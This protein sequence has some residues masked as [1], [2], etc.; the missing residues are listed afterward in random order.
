M[1]TLKARQR[2]RAR[3]KWIVA[4]FVMAAAIE[5]ALCWWLALKPERLAPSRTE[6]VGEWRLVHQSGWGYRGLTLM[7]D[8]EA[9]DA[10]TKGLEEA[11]LEAARQSSA[12]AA[13][14]TITKTITVPIRGLDKLVLG[15]PTDQP[16]LVTAGPRPQM[17]SWVPS[18][19]FAESPHMEA[20]AFGWP[21]LAMR[22]SAE[23]DPS[24]GKQQPFS[25]VR[26]LH[27]EPA[28]R[29]LE[30]RVPVG[31]IWKGMLVDI[32]TVG[33]GMSVAIVLAPVLRR[34]IRRARGC[35]AVCGYNLSGAPSAT[36]PECG[37]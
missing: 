36:C 16:S 18:P 9:W 19:R 31:V 1:S 17:P 30:G 34:V 22:Y 14:G 11:F 6:P 21:M 29:V 12:G 4:S 20:H 27:A 7:R 3:V 37:R 10:L 5:I 26:I 33:S 25:S 35:C 2:M 28:Q 13:Q 15:A 23:L 8:G 32:A 24:Q